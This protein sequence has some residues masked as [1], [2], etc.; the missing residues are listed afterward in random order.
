MMD[1]GKPVLCEK[2][3]TMNARDTKSLIQLAKDSNLFFMEGM[4]MRFFPAIVELRRLISEGSI[5]SVRY[6]NVS[7]GFRMPPHVTRLIQADQGAGATLEIG[8]YTIN[9]VTMIFNGEKPA[10]IHAEG[11]LTD[12]GVD[13]IVAVTLTYSGGRI[14]QLSYSVV[15]DMPCEAL[16]S[17]T[18]GDIKVPKCFWCS[19]K[20]DTP[21]GVKEYPLPKPCMST[22]FIN[23]EGF[24]YEAEEV[25]NCLQEGR[26]E[27]KVQPLSDT[28]LVAEIMD[29]IMKQIGTIHM[30]DD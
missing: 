13:T 3:L 6:V 11:V 22:I 7:F 9:F 4:W 5:G 20:L 12:E 19:T 21:E 28:M 8:V 18:K 26:K 10:K 15:A 30:K 29:E 23:S 25:R 2:P 27:S 16:V 17:G 1:A 14:A 24:C